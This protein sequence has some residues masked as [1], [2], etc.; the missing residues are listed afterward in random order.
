MARACASCGTPLRPQARFCDACGSPTEAAVSSAAAVN[1]PDPGDRASI[2]ERR[3]VSVVFT[4]LVGFTSVSEHRDAEEVRELLSRYFDASSEIVRRYGGTVEKFIGDAVMAVWGAP[5]A[6]EDDPERAVRAALEL[7]DMVAALGGEVGVPDLRARAGV[8]TGE[9]AVTIGAVGQG[10]VAGD[11]VNTSSRIQAA[12]GPGTVLVGDATRRATEAAVTYEDA[13]E[14]TMKGRSEPMRLWRAGRVVAGRGGSLK[15]TLLEPPFIGRDRE[16]RLVKELFHGSEENRRAHLVSLI[17]AA[18]TGKSRL[19]WEFEKYIDGLAGGVFWQRGRC[20]AYGEGVTYWA[21][22]EMVRMRAE[23]IE[24]EDPAVA[25]AKLSA[26]VGTYLTDPEERRWVE[27]RLAHLLGLEDRV[28]GEATELFSAWRLFFERLA[29]DPTVLVFED[30]QWADESLLDFI[31]YL[32]EWSKNHPIYVITLARPELADRRPTWG[33][34][35]R[36]FTSLYLEPLARPAMEEMLAG[37]VPGL[38]SELVDRILE[39][40]EGIP[41]YAVETIRMLLDRGL[42]ERVGDRY[43]L[44]GSLTELDVPDTLHALIAARLDGLPTETRRVLQNA[45]VLGKSFTA[46]AVGAVSGLA[47]EETD[48]RLA[49]LVRMEVLSVQADPRSPERGQYGFVQDLVR[50]VAYDTLSRRDRRARHLAAAA[51]L[52]ST[53]KA[54]DVE[55]VEVLASHFL[56]AYRLAP[57][58]PDSAEV[59]SRAAAVLVLAAEHAASL[60]ATAEGQRYYEQAAE[61]TGTRSGQA[62]LLER[63]GMMAFRGGRRDDAVSNLTRSRELFEGEQLSHAAARVLARLA[64]LEGGT[65]NLDGA[66]ESMEAAYAVLANDPPDADLGELAAELARW[67]QLMGNLDMATDRVR[68]ALDISEA[69]E[70]PELLAHALNTEANLVSWR[71]HIQEA[72]AL[73]THALKVSVEHGKTNAALRSYNNLAYVLGVRER[74]AETVPLFREG[75]AL[76]RRVGDRVWERILTGELAAALFNLGEWDESRALSDEVP[77]SM[78]EG[79]METYSGLDTVVK[80]RVYRGDTDGARVALETGREAGSSSDI[81]SRTMYHALNALVLRAEGHP[82]DALEAARTAMDVTATATQAIDYPALTAYVQAGEAALELGLTDR[83]EQLV[84][85][86]NERPPGL[87]PPSLVWHAARFRG[88]LESA[89]GAGDAADASFVQAVSGLDELGL[90]FWAAV[91]RL[92]HAESL[93]ARGHVP[94]AAPLLTAAGVTFAALGAQP[95]M[96]RTARLAPAVRVAS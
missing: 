7:V 70:L 65:G 90:R 22:A 2:A 9:A 33:G 29:V 12:A 92:E 71:G 95:W 5:V 38:P 68:V 57:D 35:R 19:V 47:V 78:A 58:A 56:E 26:C 67:H 24:G 55:I 74:W 8:L 1:G 6:H 34:G 61:L 21:L 31:E 53:W 27:P 63:A 42:L 36:N 66:V 30:L 40:A 91:A 64:E 39:R 54:D 62:E 45:A 17:G 37:L 93:T 16:L 82:A 13:G 59:R 81:Q 88:R 72:I 77:L 11:L 86:A 4:D 10:M 32:L 76:A 85:W 51:H 43:R 52:E 3:L 80:L 25:A 83:A 50:A 89:R 23:I 79:L 20:L 87:R 73:Y 75:L 60:A 15:S 49:E 14:H 44:T 94:E 84:A 48:T 96:E 41:L 46:V 69:L 18:G 28:A